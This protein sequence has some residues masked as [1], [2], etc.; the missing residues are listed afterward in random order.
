MTLGYD[1]AMKDAEVASN[2]RMMT[3]RK[4][5]IDVA[6]ERAIR[7]GATQV[8]IPGGKYKGRLA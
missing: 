4:R 1:E 7:G 5:L 6:L 8:V 2:V 3:I